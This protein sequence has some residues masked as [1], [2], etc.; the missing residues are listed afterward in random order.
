MIAVSEDD[1]YTPPAAD[2]TSP[3]PGWVRQWHGLYLPP[4]HNY[5]SYGYLE[6]FC[7][8]SV[9]EFFA[10]KHMTLF[11]LGAGRADWCMALAGM[12]RFGTLP[13][14]PASYRALA[15]EAEPTHFAWCKQC[16]EA[17]QVNAVAVHGAAG[18]T[19]GRCKFL[20]YGDP[21]SWFG[22][23]IA[24]PGEK[25]TVEVPMYTVDHLRKEYQ[26]ETISLVHMDVQGSEADCVRGARQSIAAKRVGFLLIETH[27]T[28]VEGELRGLLSPTHNL[29]VDLPRDGSLTLPGFSKKVSGKGGGV[30]LWQKK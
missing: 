3:G 7:F 13:G 12:V 20:S 26:F 29:V 15:V 16:I 5:Y 18:A 4:A 10:G 25:G 8:L 1:N 27:N 14:A 19:V 22:Q 2:T 21:L 17:Q 9:V 24:Q 23:R 28:K 11:E 30:Q 6:R